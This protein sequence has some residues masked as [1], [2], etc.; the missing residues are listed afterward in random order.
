MVQFIISTVTE[1]L[2]FS[3]QL[4]HMC[5]KYCRLICWKDLVHNIATLSKKVELPFSLWLQ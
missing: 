5:G 4:L 1:I 2:Q 3:D